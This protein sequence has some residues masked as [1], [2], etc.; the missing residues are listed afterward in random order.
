M[1][2]LVLTG[3]VLL[4]AAFV[5]TDLLHLRLTKSTPAKDAVLT[6]SPA[7]LRV[8]FNQNARMAESKLA[9]TRD[10]E[11]VVLPAVEATDDPKSFRV[12]LPDSLN[13]G[14]GAYEMTWTTAGNDGHVLKGTIPYTVKP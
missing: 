6:A 3:L 12:A 7:E 11:A 4:F 8:W 10:G 5:P 9:L 13:L 14:A 2:T 1:K